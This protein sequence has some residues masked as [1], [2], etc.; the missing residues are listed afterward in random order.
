MTARDRKLAY[1]AWITICIVWGT[2]CLE[3]RV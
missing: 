2:T 1:F 3:I